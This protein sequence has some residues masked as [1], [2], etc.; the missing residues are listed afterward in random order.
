[1]APVAIEQPLTQSIAIHVKQ[2]ETQYKD[3]NPGP[4]RFDREAEINGTADAP[5]AR[6]KHYLPTWNPEQKYHPLAPFEH[7]DR[8][9][10]AEKSLSVFLNDEVEQEDLTPSIGAVFSGIQLSSL[11]DEGKNQL[12]LLTAQRKVLLFKNQDFT[13]LSIED[14]LK[15]AGYFGRLHIHPTSGSPEGHPEVHI[16]HRGTNDPTSDIL[17]KDRLNTIT[18]HSDVTYEEQPPGTTLLYIFDKPTTGG[19][20]VFTNMVEAYNR[21][22][23]AFQAR[24]HGLEAMH[25]GI[26]QA[27]ASRSRGGIVRREPVTHQ[28]PIVRTHPVTGEKALF[29][30]PQ[31]KPANHPSNNILTGCAL[32]TRYIVG[33]KREESDAILNLLYNHIATGVDFQTRVKWSENAVVVWDV[34]YFLLGAYTISDS[35]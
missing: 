15:F 31:C 7:V 10:H 2:N 27:E 19:D 33:L 24:L 12:A 20:T 35:E 13:N 11:I 34:S 3:Q 14:A 22:S 9:T 6:Y 30:N 16:V 29:V 25:S 8:G 21:L 1:M 28:H 5:G 23:P 4:E 26:E 32:V 18:W 17:L